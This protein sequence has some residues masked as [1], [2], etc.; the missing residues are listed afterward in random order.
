MKLK[1]IHSGIVVDINDT[2]AASDA[3]EADAAVTSLK[4][5]ILGVQTADCVPILISDV[6]GQVVAAIHAG[7]RGTAARI[8]ETTVLRL[9]MEFSVDPKNLIASVGPHIGVCCYEVGQEVVTT[10]ANPAAFEQRTEWSK[11]HLNLGSAN[12][13]H[14]MNAGIPDERIEVSSLCTRCRGDLF[15]S[16]RREGTKMGHMLSVIGIVP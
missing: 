7:W 8:A 15:F 10:M 9:G 1:Q 14:L 2:S 16:Y 13:Q 3:V 12:R 6:G 4:G 5:I 11:P